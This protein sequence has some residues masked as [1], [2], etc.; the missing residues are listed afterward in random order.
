MPYTEYSNRVT[1]DRLADSRHVKNDNLMSQTD[2]SA[3]YFQ[4]AISRKVSGQLKR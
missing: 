3:N 1:Q 2:P 4:L